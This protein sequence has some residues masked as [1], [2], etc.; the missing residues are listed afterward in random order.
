MGGKGRLLLTRLSLTRKVSNIYYKGYIVFCIY[1]FPRSRTSCGI[2]HLV[3]S[4]LN[5][6]TLDLSS[7]F[8]KEKPSS[9]I[10][11][12]SLHFPRKFDPLYFI[13]S[14]FILEGFFQ[15]NDS[16]FDNAVCTPVYSMTMFQTS[17]PVWLH[18]F[19]KIIIWYPFQTKFSLL[20]ICLRHLHS[21][22]S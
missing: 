7:Y 10:K 1:L 18:H 19:S 11:I 8:T 9:I 2:Y 5:L 12:K 4:H 6:K 17:S 3:S 13:S 22:W 16:H 14:S 20:V 21:L 15:Q